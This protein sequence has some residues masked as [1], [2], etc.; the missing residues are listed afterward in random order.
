MI[1][2]AFNFHKSQVNSRF[3]PIFINT[4]QV[5]LRGDG[6]ED[7]VVPDADLLALRTLLRARVHRPPAGLALALKTSGR[8]DH[9]FGLYD[10]PL[11]Y[12]G[13]DI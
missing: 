1:D 6:D 5:S 11:Q 3:F 4:D 9:S 12:G 10:C 8:G 2:A 7:G 13:E